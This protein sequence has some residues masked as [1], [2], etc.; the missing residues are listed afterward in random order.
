MFVVLGLLASL[1]LGCEKEES[2][3]V[4][5]SGDTTDYSAVNETANDAADSMQA[6]EAEA[7]AAEAA[8]AEVAEIKA[9]ADAAEAAAAAEAEAEAAAAV[10]AEAAAVQAA[11]VKEDIESKIET[12]A[13][14]A[15]IA[16]A[17]SQIDQVMGYIKENKF[18]LAEK[19]LAQL[20]KIKGS[21]PAGI[22]SQIENAYKA[23]D[24][25]KKAGSLGGAKLPG[26]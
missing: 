20:D 19:A 1:T 25:A 4:V 15:T 26:M 16:Q 12:A 3:P 21:L 7:A 2:P 13:D 6:A 18:D 22:Q 8:A 10:E 24:V 23:L 5:P 17:Q 14:D 9:E 11:D